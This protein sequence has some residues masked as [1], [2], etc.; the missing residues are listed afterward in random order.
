MFIIV[1]LVVILLA[2]VGLT[3]LYVHRQAS[4]ADEPDM[5]VVTSFYP[6]YVATKNVTEGLDGIILQNLSE[7]QTGCL[8]DYQLTSEDMKLLATAD[9]FIVNGGGIENFLTDI[10]EEYPDLQ[11]VNACD[12]IELAEDNAHVWMSM[13]RYKQQVQNICAGLSQADPDQSDRYQQNADAYIEKIEALQAEYADLGDALDGTPV[14]LFHE[15]YEY[16][17][18]DLGMEVVGVL[19]LD[20]ERQV[21]AGEVAETLNVIHS[22]NV[23]V[24]FAEELYGKSMGDV[25]E[26]ETGVTVLYLDALNRGDY[27]NTDSYLENMRANLELIR[28]QFAL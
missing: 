16:L 6:M 15:A 27:E 7:P 22:E 10:A 25:M 21:S 12:G 28:A 23:S 9:V 2:S 11:I 18:K 5:Q 13:D 4:H 1:M 24:I 8:H 14:V 19:D 26:K 3:A 17:A 20:E